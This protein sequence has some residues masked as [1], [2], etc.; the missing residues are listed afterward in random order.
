[1]YS[2]WAK[3]AARFVPDM[4]VVLAYAEVRQQAFGVD[5]DIYVVNVDAVKWMWKNLPKTFFHRFDTI[6]ID[7]LEAYKHPTT[8]RSKAAHKIAALKK[9]S[10]YIFEYRSGLTA[11]PNA[12]SVTELWHQVLIID[13]GDHL[14][15]SYY[16]FRNATCEAVQNGPRPE[17]IKWQDKPGAEEAVAGILAPITV[18]HLFEDCMDI[19]PNHSYAKTIQLNSN[20]MSA[21]E[22][23]KE[24]LVL[25]HEQ[26]QVVA[27]NKAVLRGKLLQLLSGAVYGENVDATQDTNDYVLLD[28]S[29]YEYVAELASEVKHSIIFFE[30][31]HQKLEISKAL[32]AMGRT[33]RII[34]GNVPVEKRGV[35]VDQYQAGMFDTMLLHP[36]TGA[37]GITLTK[38]TRSL[39]AS[40]TSRPNLH[41]QGKHRIYRGGQTLA[42]EN[43]MV[44][45]EGTIEEDVFNSW[46]GRNARMENFLSFLFSE[47]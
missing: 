25:M 3:D 21:Y 6:I 37:H 31:H 36:L 26:G 27:L 11:T 22:E 41:K 5:A 4:S 19:P 13:D 44:V 20:I 42:T 1:M 35:L 43:I 45:A 15:N 8:N 39:W 24:R 29:R 23:L 32:E 9:G 16:R 18:R 40:P 7:E 10:E 33:Y 17:H 38:G 2:A 30:W 28:T 12:L 34:D 14:G 46:E 47:K